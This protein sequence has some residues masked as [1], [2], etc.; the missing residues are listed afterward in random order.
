M[1]S[2]TAPLFRYHSGEAELSLRMGEAVCR[3]PGLR[4]EL[5][6]R[7]DEVGRATATCHQLQIENDMLPNEIA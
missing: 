7:T 2:F 6:A 5:R 1:T 4:E 3:V